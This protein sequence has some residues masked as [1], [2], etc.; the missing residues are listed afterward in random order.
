MQK[1][2]QLEDASNHDGAAGP[3]NFAF[4]ATCSSHCVEELWLSDKDVAPDDK[5]HIA[6]LR[7]LTVFKDM[8]HSESELKNAVFSK[9]EVQK[10]G[11]HD[12]IYDQE[13]SDKEEKYG[14]AIKE[15][16]GSDANDTRGALVECKLVHKNLVDLKL[17]EV[18]KYFLNSENLI[19]EVKVPKFTR[20]QFSIF[21]I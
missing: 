6:S 19:H 7:A 11:S 1:K 12:N 16:M 4:V 21:I 14:N 13:K 9:T 15:L 18:F 2:T 17:L 3:S 8:L 10:S 5:K 20:K